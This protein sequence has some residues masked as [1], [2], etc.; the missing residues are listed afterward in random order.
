MTAQKPDATVTDFV[1]DGPLQKIK[2][3]L[4]ALLSEIL[5]YLI[6][7]PALIG[8]F[9]LGVSVLDWSDFSSW[10]LGIAITIALG[11]VLRE[12]LPISEDQIRNGFFGLE[13]VE[14]A[15]HRRG[16]RQASNKSS[17]RA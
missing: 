8:G 3:F 4:A 14:A 17:D 9:V 5:S 1:D 16:K 6:A 10:V 11:W 15:K 12:I 2:A 13:T 7:I